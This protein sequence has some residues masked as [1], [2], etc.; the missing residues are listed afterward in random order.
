MGVVREALKSIT[1]AQYVGY[2]PGW[3]YTNSYTR[4][5]DNPGTAAQPFRSY[6]FY[7]ADDNNRRWVK[8]DLQYTGNALTKIAFY[9]SDNNESSYVPMFNEDGVNYVLTL[10][11]DAE[12]NLRYTE[13]GNVP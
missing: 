2:A 9:Y 12:D 10:V 3:S 6:I 11:Y 5:E 8:Q 4:G 7:G 13:W 1:I